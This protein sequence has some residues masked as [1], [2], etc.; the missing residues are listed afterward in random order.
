VT[1]PPELARTISDMGQ[2]FNPDVARQTRALAIPMHDGTGVASL[3]VIRDV[4]YGPNAR[5]RMDIYGT[6][7]QGG[8]RIIVVYVHGGGFVA[9]DK[10][11]PDG[12]PFYGN[13]AAW[14]DSLGAACVA[15]TYRLAPDHGYPAGAEDIAAVIAWLH[16]EGAAHGLD[17][18]RIVLVGQSAGAV[19]AATYLAHPALHLVDGSGVA[20]GVFLSGLYDMVAADNNPPKHAYF[21]TD[22]SLYA[23]RSSLQGLVENCYVPLLVGVCEYDPPDFQGQALLLLEALFRRDRRWPAV[24]YQA[25]HNHLSSIFL[26]GSRADTLGGPLGD[27]VRQAVG[28]NSDGN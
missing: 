10:T 18:G 24:I 5:Q 17:A 11:S 22:D 9:G 15:M 20:A 21:G 16:A 7:V 25:G 23:E 4:A 3:P 26:L 19:H 8:S 1:L 28:S 27:F 13:V 12:A 6:G 2:H 14:A